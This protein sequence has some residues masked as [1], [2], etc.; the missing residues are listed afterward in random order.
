M[1]QYAY[2]LSKAATDYKA[3]T[4]AARENNKFSKEMT[5]A[6]GGDFLLNAQGGIMMDAQGQPLKKDTTK[7]IADTIMD[8]MGNVTILYE[9]GTFSAPQKGI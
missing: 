5:E 1:N 9:D 8:N 6:S 3:F 4:D 7:K 2:K